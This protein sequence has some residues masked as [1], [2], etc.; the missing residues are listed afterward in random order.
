[1]TITYLD[2]YHVVLLQ[3]PC[4]RV[5]TVHRLRNVQT[6][7]H[8]SSRTGVSGRRSIDLAPVQRQAGQ[9]MSIGY[10]G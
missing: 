1:M 10:L 2:W 6:V 3:P 5:V 9:V 4:R 7:T 8:T